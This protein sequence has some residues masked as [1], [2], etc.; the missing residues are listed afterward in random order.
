M[1]QA[2]ATTERA[3]GFKIDTVAATVIASDGAT[4]RVQIAADGSTRVAHLR[5]AL[6]GTVTVQPA[7]Q[8]GEPV[9]LAPGEEKLWEAFGRPA[10]RSLERSGGA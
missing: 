5:E 2:A 1:H 8:T 3:E 10:R 6:D 4:V 7:R 9:A